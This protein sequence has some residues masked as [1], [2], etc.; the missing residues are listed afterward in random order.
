M[1]VCNLV[2]IFIA[3]VIGLTSTSDIFSSTAQLRQLASQE[4]SLAATV[5]KF[6]ER[7]EKRI[8]Q[9]KRYVIMSILQIVEYM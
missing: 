4:P 5:K 3:Y 8:Q 6:V 7:E 9:I 2:F 1:D